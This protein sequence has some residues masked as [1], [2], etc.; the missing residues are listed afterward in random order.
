M[1]DCPRQTLE[2]RLRLVRANASKP[3]FFIIS[4]PNK[5]TQQT[6]KKI[7]N[8]FHYAIQFYMEIADSKFRI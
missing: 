7:A 1:A 6:E 4:P 3:D 2:R 8:Q 5:K